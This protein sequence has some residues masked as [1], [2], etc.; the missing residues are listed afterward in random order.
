MK[1]TCAR[2]L[3]LALF[4]FTATLVRADDTK[5]A[6]VSG[7]WEMVR[8]FNGMTSKTTFT[9][10]QEGESLKGTAANERGDRQTPLAG[11]IKG[12]AIKFSYSMPGRDG[13][14]ARMREFSGTVEGDA[15]KL[16]FDTRA[17]KREATAKRVDG[18][19]AAPETKPADTKPKE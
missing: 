7:K 4:V 9:F 2:F 1:N 13:G 17:G 14:E 15:M 19:E 12:N 16:E 18:A 11:T 6:P 8:E 10:E 5:P 3:P